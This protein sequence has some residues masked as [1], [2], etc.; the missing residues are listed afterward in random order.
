MPALVPRKMMRRSCMKL[1][2]ARDEW[3]PGCRRFSELATGNAQQT[4][5]PREPLPPGAVLSALA[6]ARGYP[7]QFSCLG[8]PSCM[9]L[10]VA[11]YEL[12]AGCRRFSELATGN[13]QHKTKWPREPL[14]PGAVLSAL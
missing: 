10:R 9:K 6:A 1:R 14:P 7:H 13:A 8:D 12:R 11:R 2:V 3:R 4:K 5:W